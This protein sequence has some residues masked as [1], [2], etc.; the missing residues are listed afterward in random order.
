MR[1][2]TSFAKSPL[3]MLERIHQKSLSRAGA[4]NRTLNESIAGARGPYPARSR[5][6]P[7]SPAGRNGGLQTGGRRVPFSLAASSFM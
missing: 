2:A 7:L 1:V 5:H 6:Q 3:K 4:K